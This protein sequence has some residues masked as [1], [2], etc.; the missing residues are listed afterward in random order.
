MLWVGLLIGIVIG[1]NIG[2]VLMACVAV[3][4][5]PDEPWRR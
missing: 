3:N 1:G 2:A 4:R 5:V